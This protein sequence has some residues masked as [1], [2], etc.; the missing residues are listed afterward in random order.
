[1]L[2]KSLLR[3]ARHLRSARS[4][5]ELLQDGA[6]ALDFSVPASQ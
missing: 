6:G 3:A 2:S 4:L 1:M 5:Q